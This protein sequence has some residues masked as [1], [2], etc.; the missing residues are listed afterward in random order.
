MGRATIIR[1][2]NAGERHIIGSPGGWIFGCGLSLGQD[3]VGA[4]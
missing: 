3:I 1:V 2:S 4:C